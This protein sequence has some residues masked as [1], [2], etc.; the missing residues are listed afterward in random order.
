MGG[1]TPAFLR[2]DS[3]RLWIDWLG[4]KYP[5]FGRKRYVYPKKCTS[6]AQPLLP[7]RCQRSTRV[8]MGHFSLHLIGTP[9]RDWSLFNY[10]VQ[11]PPLIN[12]FILS[13]FNSTVQS[14][15]YAPF[16]SLR[17]APRFSVGA[18]TS[19][20]TPSRAP[21]RYILCRSPSLTDINTI[22][23]GQLNPYSTLAPPAARAFTLTNGCVQCRRQPPIRGLAQ[24]PDGPPRARLRNASPGL[25]RPATIDQRR[26]VAQSRR[27]MHDHA[28]GSG[29]SQVALHLST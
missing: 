21:C 23:E 22:Y 27:T 19:L 5:S 15:S 17:T 20:S 16:L 9:R 7:S 14:I 26:P 12:I 13:I 10:Y 18:H 6:S 8:G 1:S 28:S 24:A 25:R 3:A 4:N 29:P 2:S 11:L